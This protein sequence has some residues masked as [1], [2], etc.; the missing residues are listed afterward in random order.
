M[1]SQVQRR[2]HQASV[3]RVDREAEQLQRRGAEQRSAVLV[4]DDAESVSGFA[5]DPH[6]D[7]REFADNRSPVRQDELGS[8]GNDT[9]SSEK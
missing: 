3:D 4:A 9:E 8:V 1:G 5:A 7:R 2:R 6:N